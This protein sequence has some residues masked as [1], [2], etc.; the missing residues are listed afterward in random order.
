MMELEF[1]K[2]LQSIAKGTD[3][4][5]TPDITDPVISGVRG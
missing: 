4:P 2:Q 3:Y 5:R 1:E